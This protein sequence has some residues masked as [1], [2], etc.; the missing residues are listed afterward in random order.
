MA[1]NDTQQGQCWTCPYYQAYGNYCD[2][3]KMELNGNVETDE[4]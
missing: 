3:Y 1:Q 4:E 2:Y